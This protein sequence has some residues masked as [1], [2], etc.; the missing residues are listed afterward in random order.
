M[1]S[2]FDV[3]ILKLVD[4]IKPLINIP[5]IEEIYL[6]GSRVYGTGSLRSDI[7]ILI[8][9]PKGVRHDDILPI[10]EN[11]NVLDIFETTTKKEAR[12]FAND[13]RLLRENL[14]VTID[15]KLLWSRLEGYVEDNLDIFDEQ[16]CLLNYDYKMSVMPT[17]TKE[18]ERF[19][20][21]Y[22]KNSIFI[23]MPFHSEYDIIYTTIT[24]YFKTKGI[25]AVRASE[26]EFSE[27]LWENIKV[28]LES[29]NTAIAIFT[30]ES[31]N[32]FNPNVALEVGYMMSKGCKICLLKD[33]RLEK[34]PSDLIE[35]LYKQ[36]DSSDIENSIPP[37]LES[38]CRDN[39]I[40]D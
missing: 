40:I 28:Y 7:D 3:R 23:I 36:Y 31:N 9:A 16:R 33:N 22:G 6:F 34:L 35:K 5:N 21:I 32:A 11:E 13:S 4:L 19:Y 27:N 26:I 8:Y 15:A 30:K 39:H 37:L 24:K 29:C 10:I 20:E 38:W 17:Y 1:A 25:T 2:R 14:I 12:S 18:E